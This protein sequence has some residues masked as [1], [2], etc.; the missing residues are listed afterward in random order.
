MILQNF[1]FSQRKKKTFFQ[2]WDYTKNHAELGRAT[3]DQKRV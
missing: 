2:R 3:H 1:H